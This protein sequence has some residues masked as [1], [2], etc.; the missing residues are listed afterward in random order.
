LII[1]RNGDQW[2]LKTE[3]KL[4]TSAYDFTPN[5]EFDETRLDGEPVKVSFNIQRK[6]TIRL[7]ILFA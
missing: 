7:L 2:T 5:V 6:K 3:S 1:S 4:K